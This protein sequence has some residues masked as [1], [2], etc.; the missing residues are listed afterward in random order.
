MEYNITPVIS[1]FIALCVA[2]ISVFVIPYI[3]QKTGAQGMENL[4]AWVS[5]AVQAAE[6]I[7]TAAD[8]EKKKD[9][10]I[11]FL[12]GKGLIVDENEVDAAIEAAVLK[13]HTDLYGAT[14]ENAE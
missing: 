4:L 14:K 5:I 12:E 9:Y 10:V 11:S 1:A 8:G 13:L 7:Y 6:Q 3:K 2:L